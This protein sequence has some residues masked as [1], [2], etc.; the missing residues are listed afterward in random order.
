MTSKSF[1][2]LLRLQSSFFH[3]REPSRTPCWL[4]LGSILEPPGADFPSLGRFI[5]SLPGSTSAGFRDSSTAPPQKPKQQE[6][7]KSRGPSKGHLHSAQASGLR[8]PGL[9]LPPQAIQT[10]VP[11]AKKARK[12]P[13]QE[14]ANTSESRHD[15]KMRK[16]RPRQQRRSK[17]PL[18]TKRLANKRWSAVSRL[19]RITIYLN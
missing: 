1:K 7:A 4:P 17:Q 11:E 14:P 19:R 5:C 15:K 3:P 8:V 10:T 2:K 9:S 6:N 18:A 16:R 12:R 13:Q